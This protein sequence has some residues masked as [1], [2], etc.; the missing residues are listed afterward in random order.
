M[1]L[2]SIICSNKENGCWRV[3][4]YLNASKSTLSLTDVFSSV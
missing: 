4:E 1:S 2:L 3:S